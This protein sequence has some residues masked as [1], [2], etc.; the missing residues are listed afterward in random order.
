MYDDWSGWIVVKATPLKA[1]IIK[2]TYAEWVC[3]PPV[4]QIGLIVKKEVEKTTESK[5]KNERK[6]VGHFMTSTI[7]HLQG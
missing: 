1:L 3:Y 5:R 6:N 7:L 2:A 4:I